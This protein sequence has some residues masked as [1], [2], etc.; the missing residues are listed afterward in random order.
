MEERQ[1][2]Y[3]GVKAIIKNDSGDILILKDAPRGK[4][5]VPGGRIDKNQ[6]IQQSLEREIQE[7]ILG[8]KLVRLGP[9]IYVATGDFTVENEHK[10]FLA[11]HD[12]TVKLPT[13]LTLSR[14]HTDFAWVNKTNLEDFEI[15]TTD[16]KAIEIAFN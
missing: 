5:E 8:A 3:I 15:F 7:E 16:K 1:S 4:W 10:L 2:F 6:T 13:E 11:F 12:A 9:I 14:E